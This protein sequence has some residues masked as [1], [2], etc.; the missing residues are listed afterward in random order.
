M[1]D[2]K[3]AALYAGTYR[4][5]FVRTIVIAVGATTLVATLWIQV[6]WG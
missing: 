2:L 3:L 1:V 6:I 4:T 5:G